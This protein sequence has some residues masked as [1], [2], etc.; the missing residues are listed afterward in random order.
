MSSQ[1]QISLGPDQGTF[2]LRTGVTGPAARTGH[3]LAIEFERWTATVDLAGDV[4][5][6]VNLTV[7]AESLQIRSGE[8][9]IT[10]MTAPE[11]AI[12]R[13]N[14]LKSLKANKFGA[15]SFRAT[16][17]TAVDGGYELVGELA[18]CGKTRPQTVSVTTDGITLSGETSLKQSDFGVKQYSL[19]M[20]ALKVA[21]EVTVGL[22][23]T[24]PA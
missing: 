18:I 7:E 15:I 1:S 19:M 20:G 22:E 13:V 9:G 2:T 10:P 11:R 8:G 17:V 16:A 23:A 24:I 12:A 4:P 21:D 5:T 14:A 3:N 6:T